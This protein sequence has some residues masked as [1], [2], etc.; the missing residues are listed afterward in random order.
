MPAPI[1]VPVLLGTV[2]PLTVYGGIPQDFF[3]SWAC[4]EDCHSTFF[5][6]ESGIKDQETFA[7]FCRKEVLDVIVAREPSGRIVCAG[8][9][10]REDIHSACFHGYCAPEYRSPNI[11]IP[12]ARLGLRYFFRR[13]GFERISVLGRWGNR[14]ARLYAVR[15]GFTIEGRLR[16]YLRYN[17]QYVDAYFGSMLK[18]EA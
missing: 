11:S 18:E 15:Q 1:D 13:H 7:R 16:R 2:G 6:Q 4:L 14:V 17:G 8:Y 12:C 3:D 9:V 10:I 5:P